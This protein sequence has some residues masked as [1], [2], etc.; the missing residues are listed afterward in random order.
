LSLFDQIKPGARLKGLDAGGIA[1]IVQVARFGADALNIVY[2]VDGRV[3]E[4]LLYRG[5]ETGFEFIE[6][7]GA[8]RHGLASV[9]TQQGASA[10]S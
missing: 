3:G 2:R 5:E 8:T 1:E 6:V 9:G 10:A 4:R 7:G